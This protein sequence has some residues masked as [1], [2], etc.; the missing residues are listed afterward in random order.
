VSLRGRTVDLACRG[1]SRRGRVR[2]VD[3]AVAQRVGRRCR[4][5]SRGGRLSRRATSCSRPS[6]AGRGRLG[7]LRAGKVP[8][9]ARVAGRGLPRGAYL[10]VARA[11]DTGGA[12][13]RKLRRFN[14]RTFRIR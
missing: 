13:E 9:T 7:R 11:T 5:L 4:W 3:V 8:W 10:V 1:N 12:V 6:F 14:R 2:A